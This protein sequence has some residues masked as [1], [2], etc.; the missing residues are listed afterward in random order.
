MIFYCHAHTRFLWTHALFLDR[1]HRTSNLCRRPKLPSPLQ[2]STSFCAEGAKVIWR[3]C[4]P[5]ASRAGISR[6]AL[7]SSTLREQYGRRLQLPRWVWYFVCVSLPARL[8]CIAETMSQ[9][10]IGSAAR[11]KSCTLAV[12]ETGFALSISVLMK[13]PTRSR[14]K[15]F[16]NNRVQRVSLL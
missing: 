9:R 10:W 12:S 16:H 3:A 8:Y 2:L 1:R 15:H 5:G 11:G 7:M 6:N 14:V 13:H 4:D